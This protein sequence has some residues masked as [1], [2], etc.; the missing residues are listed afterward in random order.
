ML[1][2][3]GGELWRLSPGNWWFPSI[4]NGFRCTPKPQEASSVEMLGNLSEI[5]ANATEMVANL[6]E[7]VPQ[8]VLLPLRRGAD[9]NSPS[10]SW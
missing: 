1:C 6:T 7:M 5:L 3:L 10:R 4:P 8:V 2:F 9:Y